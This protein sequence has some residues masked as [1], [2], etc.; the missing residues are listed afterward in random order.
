[1]RRSYRLALGIMLLAAPSLARAE[2]S[3]VRVELADINGVLQSDIR[4]HAVA[5][6]RDVVR[7]QA[8]EGETIIGVLLSQDC[9]WMLQ[10]LGEGRIAAVSPT[11][12]ALVG[13]NDLEQ[14]YARAGSKQESEAWERRLNSS[15][16]L[17]AAR[18]SLLPPPFVPPR[19]VYPWRTSTAHVVTRGSDGVLMSY[20]ILLVALDD[21]LAE[22]G[23]SRTGSVQ[24]N[25]AVVLR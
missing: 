13:P 11:S 14:Q 7:L 18:P 5:T 17:P 16:L 21:T 25:N 3:S 1:M 22:G 12:A 19:V 10:L 6:I 4:P 9:G 2:P 8:P 20:E 24:L 15:A 23:L